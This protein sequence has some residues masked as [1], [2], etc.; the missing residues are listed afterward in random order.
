MEDTVIQALYQAVVTPHTVLENP[1]GHVL[2]Q[3]GW[4]FIIVRW[5]SY[6]LIFLFRDYHGSWKPFVPP[7]CGLT[8]NTYAF[9]QTYFSVVF[10]I[11]LMGLM[12]VAL[13]SCLRLIGKK[14]STVRILNILGVTFFLPWVILQG[15]DFLVLY[16]IGWVSSV[17]IP[18][19]TAVLLWESGAAV[20]IMSE[21]CT[22]TWLEK[23]LSIAVL[24]VV[25]ILLCAALWR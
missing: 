10:G 17:I 16:T 14:I 21:T 24:T 4:L 12:S 2:I 25:W 1:K 22:L 23:I 3:Y 8:V 20:E 9:L 6:S 11:V 18:L 5:A 15:V 7:P 19:H 13:S